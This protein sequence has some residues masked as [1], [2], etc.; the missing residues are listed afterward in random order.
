MKIYLTEIQVVY[1]DLDW[2]HLN[3]D[4][5]SVVGSCGLNYE[6]W[7]SVRDGEFLA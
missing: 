7:R 2:I 1:V 3:Q 5:I 4:V 6:P